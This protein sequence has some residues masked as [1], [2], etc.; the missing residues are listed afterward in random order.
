MRNK[1]FQTKQEIFRT[2]YA[3]EIRDSKFDATKTR[4]QLMK[5]IKASS[6]DYDI[7]SLEQLSRTNLDELN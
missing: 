3:R 2:C 4:R 1:F 7:K 6:N 5:G